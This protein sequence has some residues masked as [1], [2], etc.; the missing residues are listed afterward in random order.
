[1]ELQKFGISEHWIVTERHRGRSAAI[2]SGLLRL[3]PRNDKSHQP[4]T[5]SHQP[6]KGFSLIELSIVFVVIGIL[7]TGAITFVS[8]Y[9]KGHQI[10]ETKM[11]LGA[12]EKELIVHVRKYGHLPCPASRT[13]AL[14]TANFGMSPSACN[15]APPAGTA[16]V[17]SGKVRIGMVPVKSLGLPQNYAFDGW[18]NRITYSAI[19]NLAVGQS[20]YNSYTTTDTNGVIIIQDGNGNQLYPADDKNITAYALVSHGADGKGSFNRTGQNV[21]ACG[22]A[23]KDS[24]NCDD[25]DSLF[26]DMPINDG[27]VP[28]S[29]FNDYIRWKPITSLN[30]DANSANISTAT[31]L[32]NCAAGETLI[33][34]GAGAYVCGTAGGG[35]GGS[36]ESSGGGNFEGERIDI[37]LSQHGCQENEWNDSCECVVEEGGYYEEPYTRKDCEYWPNYIW[38]SS[39]GEEPPANPNAGRIYR[40]DLSTYA[41]KPKYL[42][43]DAFCSA[44]ANKKTSADNAYATAGA[45]VVLGFIDKDNN[46][47]NIYR[48]PT[49]YTAMP[50]YSS[51][52]VYPYVGSNVQIRPGLGGINFAGSEPYTID[53]LFY[54]NSPHSEEKTHILDNYLVGCYATVNKLFYYMDVGEYVVASTNYASINQ[55]VENQN[56]GHKRDIFSHYMDESNRLIP[57]PSKTK[58]IEIRHM[59]F[60]YKVEGL[61]P[62]PNKNGEVVASTSAYVQF[63]K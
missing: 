17:N 2:Q 36:E 12:I 14:G 50:Y 8:G 63:F 40:Y 23:T 38:S 53:N 26:F 31:G 16:D 55:V 62:N 4:L 13:V 43:L 58:Y 30:L 56:I 34:D 5:N 52:M 44:T 7:M 21:V 25:N 59:Y 18:G 1:M 27:D 46:Y 48:R 60:G 54:R 39:W 28:A 29:Y 41:S 33:S 47:I 42:T 10:K 3:K 11:K 6:K 61:P 15:I 24:E 19:R 51:A 32:P 37:K 22:T 20:T 9:T 35:E 57:I 45:T 49:R